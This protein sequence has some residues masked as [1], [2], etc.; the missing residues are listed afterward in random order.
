MSI[1]TLFL[2]L[3]LLFVLVA[4]S[5]STPAA[6]SEPAQSSSSNPTPES[7]QSLPS[8]PTT[9]PPKSSA[10]NPAF[11][12]AQSSSSNST[13]EPSQSSSSNPTTEPSPTE[14]PVSASDELARVDSEGAV[15]VSV[16]PINLNDPG[17]TLIFEVA[18]NTHSVDLSMDLATMATLNTDTGTSVQAATWD[19]PRGGHHVEGKLSFPASVDGQPLLE[20]AKTLTLII[21]D[22]DALE[23]VLTWEL[24]A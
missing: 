5:P 24:S 10:S 14:A 18:L 20:G 15:E 16:T 22:L 4:C 11:E 17:E 6:T 7:A 2:P 13:S 19:A 9:E 3:I 23:R 21:K 1:R 12:P 8:N